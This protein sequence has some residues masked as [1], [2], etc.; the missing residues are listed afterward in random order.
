[1]RHTNVLIVDAG[2]NLGLGA[3]LVIVSPDIFEKLGMPSV[4][5]PFY[6]RI[7]GAVLF[8]IGLALL[9]ER[10]RKPHGMV[11]LGLGG[12]VSIN[13][14]GA[15]VLAAW[16]LSTNQRLPSRGGILLWGLVVVLVTISLVELGGH[17]RKEKAD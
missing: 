4:T 1:M 2:I 16:L 7:L 15:I 5:Q 13:L 8:G 6:A 14:C 3:L 17:Y 10:F 9:L 12:A 11:G